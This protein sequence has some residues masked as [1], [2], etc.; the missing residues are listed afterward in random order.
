MRTQRFAL[1]LCAVAIVSSL[2]AGEDEL[3]LVARDAEGHG[4]LCTAQKKTILL[5]AGTPEQ[6]GAAHGRLL[7]PQ[8][9]QTMARYYY[10]VGAGFSVSQDT[11]FVSHLE[12]VERRAAPYIPER[13]VT[14]CDALA[15]A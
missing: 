7:K 10:L 15:K 5:V 4:L 11:W 13:F 2:Q 3:R 1:L 6:M 9:A 14:E 12:E 8:V